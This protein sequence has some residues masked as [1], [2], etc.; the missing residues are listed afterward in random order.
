VNTRKTNMVMSV[1]D[2]RFIFIG[3][4]IIV[5]VKGIGNKFNNMTTYEVIIILIWLIIL[6]VNLLI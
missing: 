3:F 5:L 4:M 2:L 1:I 6:Y